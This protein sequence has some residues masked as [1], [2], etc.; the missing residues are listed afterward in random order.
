MSGL[1]G[2]DL[3]VARG[4]RAILDGV[5][6]AAA[7]GALTGLIGPNGAGKTTLLRCLAGL[8][9]PDGG[10]VALDG[11]TLSRVPR[12]VLARRLAYL[13]QGAEV[14]W[15]LTVDRLVALGRLPHLG[16]WSRPGAADARAIAAAME[17]CDVTAFAGRTAPSLSGGERARV[18]LARALAAEPDVLLADE[19]VAGLDPQHQLRVMDVLKTLARSGKAVVVVL[20][21]LTLA[22]RFCDRLALLHAGRLVAE[23]TP[24]AVLRLELMEAVYGVAMAVAEIEGTRVLLPWRRAGAGP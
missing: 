23:G 17:R 4:G 1:T 20:H 2:R 9:D 16:P 8:M 24:D 13:A 22:A 21:D 12:A 5:D 7:P 14:H 3:R 6:F 10:T 15:P 18:L 11:A 19:P